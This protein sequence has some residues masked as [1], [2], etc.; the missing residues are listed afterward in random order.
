MKETIK[1]PFLTS[2]AETHANY[3]AILPIGKMSSG[4]AIRLLLAKL[5]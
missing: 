5:S 3:T 1:S 4:I 2:L